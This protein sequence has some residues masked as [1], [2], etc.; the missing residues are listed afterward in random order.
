MVEASV[1]SVAFAAA[2]GPTVTTRPGKYRTIA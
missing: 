2:V 1:P